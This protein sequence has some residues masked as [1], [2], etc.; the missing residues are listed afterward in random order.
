MDQKVLL[1]IG[2]VCGAELEKVPSS[3][4][5]LQMVCESVKFTE[6][7]A[8]GLEYVFAKALSGHYCSLIVLAHLG[9]LGLLDSDHVGLVLNMTRKLLDEGDV[10]GQSAALVCLSSFPLRVLCS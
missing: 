10:N 4:I 6:P 8:A 9:G 3:F 7:S 1:V 5:D 2:R